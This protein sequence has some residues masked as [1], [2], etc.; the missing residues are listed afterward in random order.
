M[1]EKL[2]KLLGNIHEA[3]TLIEI[4][5]LMGFK[6]SDE[7]R[8]L[9]ETLQKL[10]AEYKVF[11]TKKEKYIL[12]KNC[13]SLKIGTLSVNKKGFGFVILPEEDDIYIDKANLKDAIDE[14]IVLCEVTARTERKEGKI[15]KVIKRD[16]KNVVGEIIKHN[17]KMYLKLDDTKKDITVILNPNTT[18]NCVEGHKVLV[19]ITEHIKNHIY[20]GDVLKIIGHK[21]DPQVD[22]ISMVYMKNSIQKY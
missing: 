8:E 4:N 21:N 6:T 18:H 15:I 14:D 22:L 5:D 17:N 19:E 13:P 12:L 1:E 7:L 9:Q 10:I 16:L 2:I 11:Y 20:S 3:K